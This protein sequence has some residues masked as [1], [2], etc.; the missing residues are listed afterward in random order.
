M[1]QSKQ[2]RALFDAYVIT[3]LKRVC[4]DRIIFI[5]LF[6][7]LSLSISPSPTKI[8]ICYFKNKCHIKL[9]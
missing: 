4:D 8:S 5:Y 7:E 2:H 1:T 9:S 3:L 6:I